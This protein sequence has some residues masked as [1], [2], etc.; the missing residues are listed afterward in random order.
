MLFT[1][2]FGAVVIA[3]CQVVNLKR[4]IDMEELGLSLRGVLVKAVKGSLFRKRV[5]F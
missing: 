4:G 2:V 1:E 3:V 5:R